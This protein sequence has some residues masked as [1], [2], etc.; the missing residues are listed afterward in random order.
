M[1]CKSRR[2]ALESMH[3]GRCSEVGPY[4][5]VVN[6]NVV[7][8]DETVVNRKPKPIRAR[9]VSNAGDSVGERLEQAGAAETGVGRQTAW[10]QANREKYN[11]K[12]RDYMKRKRAEA[13]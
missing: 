1:K 5:V 10:Q 3:K 2:C 8:T 12:M 11:A 13:R 4:A 6:K 9:D 7:N